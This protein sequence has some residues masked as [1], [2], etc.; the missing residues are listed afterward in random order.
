MN[1]ARMSATPRVASVAAAATLAIGGAAVVPAFVPDF[2]PEAVAQTNKLRAAEGQDFSTGEFTIVDG[3]VAL[4]QPVKIPDVSL[5][6]EATFN[7]D[8]DTLEVATGTWRIVKSDAQD[9]FLVAFIPK[10][11]GLFYGMPLKDA[12]YDTTELRMWGKRTSDGSRVYTGQEVSATPGRNF[13]LQTA[14][15]GSDGR[16][17]FTIP[18]GA[19]NIATT[20]DGV[21]IQ[22][23]NVTVDLQGKSSRVVS[24]TYGTPADPTGASIMSGSQLIVFGDKALD[25]G[26]TQTIRTTDNKVVEENEVHLIFRDMERQQIPNTDKAESV[27]KAG[28]PTRVTSNSIPGASLYF[29]TEGQP[30]DAK[31]SNNS[32]LSADPVSYMAPQF[33]QFFPEDQ[34]KRLSSD[35]SSQVMTKMEVPGE[36]TW[37]IVGVQGGPAL[38]FTPAQGFK[39]Y[40]TPPRVSY[41]WNTDM[42][43][44]SRGAEDEK[45]F[46]EMYDR[47]MANRDLVVADYRDTPA[48]APAVGEPTSKERET[49]APSTSKQAEQDKTSTSAPA[50]SK[51]E[52]PTTSKSSGDKATSTKAPAPSTSKQAEQDKA[53][54]SAPATSKKEE[55]TTS[56]SSGDKATSTK[57]PAPST[58]KQAEQDK[59]SNGSGDVAPTK[60]IVTKTVKP[61]EDDPKI[62]APGS[63][64]SGATNSD[65]SSRPVLPGQGQGGDATN[66]GN[67]SGTVNRPSLPGQGSN[68]PAAGAGNGAASEGT[69][70]PALPGQ[71]QNAESG[72]NTA[73]ADNASRESGDKGGQDDNAIVPIIEGG[74]GNG[75][76]A[77]P[78]ETDSGSRVSVVTD[79]NGDATII[80]EGREDTASDNGGGRSVLARTGADM[81]F[82][83][84]MLMAVIAVLGGTAFV[85]RRN[86][87][88]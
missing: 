83:I 49:P 74:N 51:K 23:N 2:A 22:G 14:V 26:S 70:R 56:K 52:E 5:F 58:S 10:D 87:A 8:K 25:K 46:R 54:T 13:G 11:Q 21:E 62:S 40:P 44:L 77:A 59:P 47:V 27:Y 81:Q 48:P 67:T 88:K 9:E 28:S 35:F 7:N 42:N 69:T 78:G 55:P 61:I 12:I 65:P 17:T 79:E 24:L 3:K 30:K 6:G 29:P 20:N 86:E 63:G 80:T 64:T 37:Q 38:Q 41:F 4:A 39:G 43:S 18:E 76:N 71:S 82:V 19:S 66:G 85:R 36:G 68:D 60:N 32:K 57:A 45:T 34:A 16:A 1:A 53:S 31:L 72:E 73:P 50:T 84:A 75:G 33:L 15:A